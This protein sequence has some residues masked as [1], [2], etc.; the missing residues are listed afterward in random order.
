VLLLNR[1][2]FEESLDGLQQYFRISLLEVRSR[3]EIRANHFQAV[4]AGLVR[5]QHECGSLECLFNDGDLAFV[6]FKVDNLLRF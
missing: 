4:P 6:D 3:K 1:E 2:E 5:T